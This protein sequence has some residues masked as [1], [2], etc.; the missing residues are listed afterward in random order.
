MVMAD[1]WESLRPQEPLPGQCCGSGC[2]PCVFDIYA[3]QLERWEHAKACDDREQLTGESE[4]ESDPVQVIGAERWSSFQVVRVEQQTVD[5]SLYRLQLPIGRRLGLSVGQHIVLRGTV[6]D[7]EI[8]RAYTPVSPL[9]AEGY[10]EVLIKLYEEGLMSQYVRTWKEGTTVQWRGPFGG[11]PYKPNQYE[12]LLLLAS[13]TGVTPMLPLLQSIVDNEEDETF[14]DVVCCCRTFPEV[15]LKPRLQE[16]AAYWNIRTQFVLSEEM[17][18]ETV[19]WSYREKVQCGR[20]DIETISRFSQQNKHLRGVKDLRGVCAD[21]GLKTS[22]L[23]LTCN[24]V[25]SSLHH[26]LQLCPSSHLSHHAI[27]DTFSFSECINCSDI[28]PS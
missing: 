13:G 23:L 7:L 19:P 17:A 21:K 11:F 2:K 24:C 25:N 16:L 22:M 4:A 12:Q 5:T 14:V 28:M 20:L 15:Y 1:D 10:F 27:I 18:P 6:N 9:H 8:Q 3:R 26:P